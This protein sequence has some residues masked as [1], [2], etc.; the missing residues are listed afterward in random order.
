MK[1]KVRMDI[2]RKWEQHLS[3]KYKYSIENND[4]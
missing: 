3:E 2:K 1:R 4:M